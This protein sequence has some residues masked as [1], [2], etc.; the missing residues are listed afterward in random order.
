MSW[1]RFARRA[2][3]PSSMLPALESPIAHVI[4]PGML[5][6]DSGRL[7]PA[8]ADGERQATVLI[9]GLELVACYGSVSIT[10]DCLAA[11]LEAGVGVAYLSANGGRLVARLTPEDDPRVVGRVMQHRVLADEKQRSAI[12]R[13]IVAEKIRSQAGA[14][15]HY[16]RQGK[17][18]TGEQLKK[19]AALEER[20]GASGSLEELLG[21]EGT[22]SATW[23]GVFA[24]LL[25]SPWEFSRRS[26]RPPRDP[27]NA[28]LSLGYTLLYHRTLAAIQAIGL[29]PGLGALHAYRAGRQSLACDLMEPLRVPIVDRWAVGLLNQRRVAS[30]DFLAA[31]AEGV[32]LTKAAF[33]RVIADWERQWEDAK[34]GSIVVDRVRAF[35]R[36]LR[37][38]SGSFRA[39]KHDLIAAGVEELA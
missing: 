32:R 16:Q 20:A 34:S 23:F 1:F 30:D 14:A 19:L 8:D 39:V 4:G 6:L 2:P 29:E 12:A 21:L 28:V 11:L 10:P 15:R 7:V 37:E 25:A 31:D 38:R 35:A 3:Q 26:R 9:A 36:D 22:A 24:K 13:E 18:V 27:V 5:S 33:P 17:P